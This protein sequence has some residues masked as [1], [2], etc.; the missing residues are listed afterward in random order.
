MKENIQTVLLAFFQLAV[1]IW[2]GYLAHSHLHDWRVTITVG[3]LI[4][5]LMNALLIIINL[6][7]KKE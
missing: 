3:I 2:C 1:A 5:A 6:E 4:A 7:E